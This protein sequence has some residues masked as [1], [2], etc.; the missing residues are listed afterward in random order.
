MTQPQFQRGDRVQVSHLNEGHDPLTAAGV[1]RVEQVF[2][3]KCARTTTYKLKGN[4]SLWP[5]TRLVPA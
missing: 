4:P 5:E 1:L 2:R 3:G